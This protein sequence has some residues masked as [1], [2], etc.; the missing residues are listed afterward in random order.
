MRLV[1]LD[2]AKED[3]ANIAD[4]IAEQSKSRR[5]GKDFAKRIYE[6]CKE[7][8]SIKGI[9]GVERP[10]LRAGLR[11]HP[12]GNYVIFFMYND[13]NLEVVTII[14]GHR[15]IETLFSSPSKP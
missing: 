9:I 6:K 7:L 15:D 12:F 8:A 14:E 4:Y 2:Q 13:N 11:S 3:I 10:E 1:L 5:V